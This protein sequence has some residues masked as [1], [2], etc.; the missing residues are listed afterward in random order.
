MSLKKKQRLPTTTIETTMHFRPTFSNSF[1][2]NIIK[3]LKQSVI[4]CITCSC[5]YFI[6]LLFPRL[7]FR[8]GTRASDCYLSFVISS[9]GIAKFVIV[10]Y[11]FIIKFQS[12]NPSV[13]HIKHN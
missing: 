11:W 7:T 9:R 13:T 8:D 5:L 2:D 6:R 12:E 3:L 10:S 4:T 1:N